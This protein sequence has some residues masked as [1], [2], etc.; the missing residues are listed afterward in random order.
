MAAATARTLATHEPVFPLFNFTS[1]LTCNPAPT[2]VACFQ[3]SLTSFLYAAWRTEQ[4]GRATRRGEEP[5]PYRQVPPSHLT[6]GAGLYL[7][8]YMYDE[9]LA[10]CPSAHGSNVSRCP[11]Q[12]CVLVPMAAT[13][14]SAHGGSSAVPGSRD[15]KGIHGCMDACDA[16]MYLLLL[17]H[18]PP[19]AQATAPQQHLKRPAFDACAAGH[20]GVRGQV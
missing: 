17:P 9:Q 2:S 16:C 7:Q 10:A 14:P 3:P 5:G 13:C 6:P 20:P 12:Q 15:C 1:P 18:V 8:R 19:G 11:W 4:G